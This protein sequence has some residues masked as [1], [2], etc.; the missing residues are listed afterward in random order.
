MEDL[1]HMPEPNSLPDQTSDDSVLI[2]A[3]VDSASGEDIGHVMTAI[4]DA[5]AHNVNLV[6]SLTK[7]GRPGYLL[8]IDTPTPALP[9]I[10]NL[11]VTE[12]GLLGWR[13]LVS[14]HIFLPTE[15]SKYTLVLQFKGKRLRLK[16]PL[17]ITRASDGRTI[18]SVDYQFCLDVKRRLKA[19]FGFDISLRELRSSIL[20]AVR[21]GENKIVLGKG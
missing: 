8:I 14:Q 7:K 10:E 15:I 5:G 11:L 21:R 4:Q 6:P 12:L 20:S 18:E 17:K 2:L 19:E 9:R 3:Q 13:R 1:K 16:V